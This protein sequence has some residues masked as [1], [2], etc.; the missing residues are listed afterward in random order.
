MS[1]EITQKKKVYIKAYLLKELAALYTV[2]T[3]TIKKWIDAHESIGKRIG[4]YYQP[5][6]VKKIFELIELPGHCELVN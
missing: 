4:Y 5:G 1:M 2:D 6:Q 3:R